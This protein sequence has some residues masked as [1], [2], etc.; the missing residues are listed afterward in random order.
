MAESLENAT[1]AQVAIVVKDVEAAADFYQNV[2]GFPLL[3]KFPGL[4]FFRCGEVRLMLSRA[5]KPEHDHA[6]SILYFRVDDIGKTHA[7]MK[8]RGVQFVDEPHIVHRDARHE[9]WMSFFN[10]CEGNLFA[11]TSEKA[12]A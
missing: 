6:A 2:L 12:V 7:A 10:D 9:L 5:E 8:A 4:A 11:I 1:L 3:F